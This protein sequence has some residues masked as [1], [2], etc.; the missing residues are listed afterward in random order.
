V[1]A[2][3]APQRRSPNL[4]TRRNSPTL[5]TVLGALLVGLVAGIVARMILPFDVFRRVH[6][7]KSW[8]ISILIGLAGAIAGW[9]FFTVWIGIGDTDVFD[10]GGILG[11][12]LGAIVVLS[13]VNWIVRLKRIVT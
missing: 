4:T 2:A 12:I 7:L 10:W 5:T 13:L 3:A 6:G 1:L 11:S 8:G 9:L